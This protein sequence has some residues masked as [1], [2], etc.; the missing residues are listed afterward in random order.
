MRDQTLQVEVA[1]GMLEVIVTGEALDPLRIGAGVF[2]DGTSLVRHYRSFIAEI[3]R[4][5]HDENGC[6]AMRIVL[7]PADVCEV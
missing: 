7:G 1:A 2:Q 4:E 3:A 5:K 6:L